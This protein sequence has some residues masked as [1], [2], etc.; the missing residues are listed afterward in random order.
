MQRK[1]LMAA[2]CAED[3]LLVVLGAEADDVND[4]Q[5]GLRP[6]HGDIQKPVQQ[7]AHDDGDREGVALVALVAAVPADNLA[8]P[9]NPKSM[10]S[11]KSRL[12]ECFAMLYEP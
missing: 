12:C 9:T 10:R 8:V 7:H 11:S 2:V 4:E 1:N 5:T 6:Q 3:V